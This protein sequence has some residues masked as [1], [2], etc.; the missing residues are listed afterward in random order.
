M[1]RGSGL[2]GPWRRLFRDVAGIMAACLAM[3]G[4]GIGLDGHCGRVRDS[5]GDC[6]NALASASSLGRPMA[7]VG[8]ASALYLGRR[9]GSHH[10]A[11]LAWGSWL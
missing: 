3:L 5:V 10:E 2:S 11:A 4:P 8:L 7:G 1:D 6:G 9:Q